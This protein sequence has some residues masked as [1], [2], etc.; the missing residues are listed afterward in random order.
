MFYSF[1]EYFTANSQIILICF[2]NSLSISA[3][4]I[5]LD[6]NTYLDS[7]DILEEEIFLEV[8]TKTFS[9]LLLSGL[10]CLFSVIIFKE[11]LLFLKL[12]SLALIN[13][14]NVFPCLLETSIR[15]IA[16]IVSFSLSHFTEIHSNLPYFVSLW[17]SFLALFTLPTSP[18]F[19]SQQLHLAL[20]TNM[21]LLLPLYVFQ[22]SISYFKIFL[23]SL[24]F[25]IEFSKATFFNVETT[26]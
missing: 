7:R 24:L 3:S 16:Y 9:R 19:F 12:S 23:V 18:F 25:V 10:L 21:K 1:F 14:R 2:G 8:E 15:C 17:V 5:L 6:L 11:I 4:T 20:S 22:I 26:F 13:L